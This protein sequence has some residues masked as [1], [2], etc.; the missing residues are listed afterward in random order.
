MINILGA[1]NAISE[2]IAVMD[3][4]CSYEEL[5]TSTVKLISALSYLV[6]CIEGMQG[7][8]DDETGSD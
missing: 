3:S 5:R 2:A 1:S 7:D 6:G 4:G 8:S